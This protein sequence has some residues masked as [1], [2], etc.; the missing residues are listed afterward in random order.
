MLLVRTGIRIG[1]A[2]FL[3]VACI[4]S[5]SDLDLAMRVLGL[6]VLTA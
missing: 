1:V 4:K 6:G 2:G 5:K 3:R